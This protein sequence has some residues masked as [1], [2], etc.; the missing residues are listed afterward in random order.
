[1][2][3]NIN[4]KNLPT[5]VVKREVLGKLIDSK[6]ASILRVLL[7]A[8]EELY[9]KEIAHQSRVPIASAYRILKELTKLELIERRVWKTA[10]VYR[11]CQ[12]DEVEFLKELF[13]DQINPIQEFVSHV[14]GFSGITDMLLHGDPKKGNIVIIGEF[15]NQARVQEVAESL[16]GSISFLCLTPNQYAQMERMGMYKEVTKLL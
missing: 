6:K 12:N 9:L 10:K 1:M 8:K 11:P 2:K 5:K 16:Q 3:T 15:I 13:D 4:H 14:K 7:H